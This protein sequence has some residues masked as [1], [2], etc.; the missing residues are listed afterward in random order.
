MNWWRA[1]RNHM[2]K[3]KGKRRTVSCGGNVY[4]GLA[5]R[6]ST[7][8]DE[9]RQYISNIIQLNK[10]KLN[11]KHIKV[12]NTLESI[13]KGTKMSL[14]F[15]L[16]VWSSW[17]IPLASYWLYSD[18]TMWLGFYSSSSLVLCRKASLWYQFPPQLTVLRFPFH[19]LIWFLL[20]LHQFM[21][22]AL[23][24]SSWSP[25]IRILLQYVN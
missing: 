15:T 20:V 9:T 17:S 10:I 25:V 22:H 16:Q 23:S 12:R 3:W 5:F 2:C 24:R 1:R 19:L 21:K 6:Q 8:D 13:Q 7:N 11:T 4:Q 18:K 14:I